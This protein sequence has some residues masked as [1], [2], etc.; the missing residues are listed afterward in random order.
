M[1]G[2]ASD[3]SPAVHFEKVGSEVRETFRKIKEQPSQMEET[4]DADDL[5]E[6][7]K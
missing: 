4:Y 7:K 5:K 2:G 1:T 6:N 3:K